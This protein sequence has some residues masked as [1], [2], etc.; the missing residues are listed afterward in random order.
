M[1]EENEKLKPVENSAMSYT[2][3]HEYIQPIKG[4]IGPVEKVES[5]EELWRDVFGWRDFKFQYFLEQLQK[6]YT[7][8]RK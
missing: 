3:A 7:I 6:R 4:T 1:K 2:E 5:Q 8:I